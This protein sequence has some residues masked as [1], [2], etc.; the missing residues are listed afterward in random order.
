LGK[1]VLFIGSLFMPNNLEG[2]KWYLNNIHPELLQTEGYELIIVGGTGDKSE[3]YFQ[4]EFKKYRRISLYCNVSDLAPFYSQATVFINPMLHGA[5][6]K[7]KTIN[8]VVNGLPI[9]STSKGS[10]GIGL[11]DK[12]MSFIA[13]KPTKFYKSILKIFEMKNEDKIK[14]VVESQKHLNENN[15]LKIMKNEFSI[16]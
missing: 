14:M 10:E 5:G 2:L 8:A 6:V 9:V 16:I 12:K 1:K 13:D 15:Y 11:I 4:N 3:E 7:L